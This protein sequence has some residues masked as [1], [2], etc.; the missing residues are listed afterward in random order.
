[1]AYSLLTVFVSFLIPCPHCS[2][3]WC[4]LRKDRKKK[5]ERKTGKHYIYVFK[6]ES[7][8]QGATWKLENHYQSAVKIDAHF[9]DATFEADRQNYINQEAVGK[10]FHQV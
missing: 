9:M 7:T 2:L 6:S 5:K 1:M 10:R 4:T 8:F 3:F